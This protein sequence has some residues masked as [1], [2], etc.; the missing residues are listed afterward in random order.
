MFLLCLRRSKPSMFTLRHYPVYSLQLHVLDWSTKPHVM[1]L[2]NWFRFKLMDWGA[3]TTLCTVGFQPQ[4]NCPAFFSARACHV[5]KDHVVR[6]APPFW[7]LA[8]PSTLLLWWGSLSM[9]CCCS[10]PVSG[11][12]RPCGDLLDLFSADWCS[13]A[14]GMATLLISGFWSYTET[15]LLTGVWQSLHFILTLRQTSILMSI[16]K[17]TSYIVMYC[18]WSI[19]QNDSELF[20]IVWHYSLYSHYVFVLLKAF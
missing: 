19:L 15:W 11:H 13:M 6:V 16:N 18:D 7:A 20:I 2:C 14:P 9:L 3:A 1:L 5:T 12:K 10:F 8:C 4:A 17:N